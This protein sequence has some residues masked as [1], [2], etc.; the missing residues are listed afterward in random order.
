MSATAPPLRSLEQESDSSAHERSYAGLVVVSALTLLAVG[1]HGYYPYAEDGGLYLAGVKRVLHPDLYPHWSGFTTAQMRFSLFAP[2][3]AFLVRATHISVMGM[4]L[5]L[6]VGSIWAVLFAAWQIAVRCYSRMEERLGAVT[7]LALL[8][9]V[10]VGGTSLMLM[11]PY[12]S[13]RSI[14]TACSLLA[15]MAASDIADQISRRVRVRGGSVA[16]CLGSIFLAL[17]VHPLMAAYA[18]GCVLALLIANLIVGRPQWA[19]YVILGAVTLGTAILLMS[20]TPSTPPGYMEVARTRTYWF[21]SEWHWYELAGLIIPLAVLA[22]DRFGRGNLSSETVRSFAQMGL[23]A[24]ALSIVVALGFARIDMSSYAVA[25]LQPLRVFQ[26][27]YVITIVSVGAALGRNV[28]KRDSWRWAAL[29]VIAGGGMAAVQ[30]SVFP[31]SSHVDF[32]WMEPSNGWEQ[33]FLWIRS[34]TSKD[35]VFAMDAN[36]IDAPGEDSQNFRAIAE[37][38][39]IP[40]YSK[41]GGVASIAPDLTPE[42]LAGERAQRG[43]DHA[44]DKERSSALRSFGVHWVVLTRDATTAFPCD[45]MNSVVKVCRVSE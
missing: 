21:L 30:L 4:M 39:A 31:S 6:Y 33:A 10:P 36:Y 2:M 45:Y 27:I 34:N 26:T 32:P 1:V 44:N 41:D 11:D 28:L 35:A 20:F 29:I 37:R 40:D 42:W 5:L 25:R 16:V 12:V 22:F 13:A 38:S 43:L 15:L 14:S 24:G 8:L 19:A 23:I 17:L 9:T 18:L 7:L 3:V